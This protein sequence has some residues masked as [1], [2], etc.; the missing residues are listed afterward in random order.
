M[1]NPALKNQRNRQQLRVPL[2]RLKNPVRVTVRPLEMTVM[3]EVR[4]RKRLQWL[5]GK[6]QSPVTA[7]APLENVTLI[8]YKMI[9]LITALS[10][11]AARNIQ[12]MV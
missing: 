11:L 1:V 5:P 7:S 9:L 4:A 6:T 12:E 10:I 2:L 3:T 8:L